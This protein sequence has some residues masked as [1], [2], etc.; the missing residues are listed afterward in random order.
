[1]LYVTTR[2]HRDAY[3]A[4]RVLRESRG[5]DGG[6]YLPFRMPVF[7]E[8]EL[9]GLE[10]LPFTARIAQVLNTL[11]GTR[12]TQWDV[13]FCVGRHPVRLV[14]LP[15]KILLAQGWH[16][17]QGSLSYMV[18]VLS[19]RL[20]QDNQP[21][22][23]DWTE[24]AVRGAVLFAVF[25]ELRREGKISGGQRVDVAAICGDCYGPISAWYARLWGL[26][27][28]N[29]IIC[30]NENSGLWELFHRGQLRTDA[31]S[32]KTATPDAD[33]VLPPGL[34]RLIFAAGG[35]CEVQ[36]Y[37]EI[38]GRGGIYAPNEAILRKL[39][40]GLTVSVVG[41]ERM[42]STIGTVYATSGCVLSP[43]SALCHAGVQ[44][45]RAGAGENRL[46]L[47]FSEKSPRLDASVVADAF[48]ITTEELDRRQEDSR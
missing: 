22:P 7:S 12:L 10:K 46:A 27:I 35:T 17:S 4:Q 34:E 1:M 6:L 25:S 37:L 18:R 13:D 16:N 31:L 11:C 43:Y 41:R 21:Q 8:T 9:E 5:P 20:R 42:E 29:I 36:R 45:Y 48:G 33:A 23:S 44:D 24:I 40:R 47:V 2:N 28:G 19:A 38:C 3:T 14:S 15:Q 26:P 30:C 39:C 32:V